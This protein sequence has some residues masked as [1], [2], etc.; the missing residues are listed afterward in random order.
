MMRLKCAV[1]GE[2]ALRRGFFSPALAP[3]PPLDLRYL[4]VFRL[5]PNRVDWFPTEPKRRQGKVDGAGRLGKH[6]LC[7]LLQGSGKSAS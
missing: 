4:E 7:I 3:S 1:D 2:Y 5:G 6:G